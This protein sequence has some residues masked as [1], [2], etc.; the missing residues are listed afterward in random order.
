MSFFYKTGDL[1]RWLPDGNIEFIGRIDNQIKI[2]GYRIE[3]GEIESHLAKHKD[4]HAVVVS[5]RETDLCVYFAAGVKLSAAHL[6]EYLTKYLPA[7]MIPAYFMQL[8]TIPLTPGGKIDKKAL[9]G[10]GIGTAAENYEAPRGYVEEKLLDVWQEVLGYRGIGINDNF[11]EIGGDSIKAIQVAARLRTH[12]LGLGINQLFLNSTIKTLSKTVTRIERSIP[13]EIVEGQVELTPIQHWFFRSDC[14]CK[15][16]FNQAV[17]LYRA[18]GFAEDSLKRVLT[19]IAIHHDALR[20]VYEINEK[21][22]IQ[23]NRGING[24]LFDFEVMDFS[25]NKTDIEKNI[26]VEVD[27][28]QQGIDLKTGPLMKTVLFKTSQG[29]HLLMV[30]HHLVVDGVSWRILLEDLA[31]G[32]TRAIR[33]EEI[34]FPEKTDSFRH[35]ARELTGYAR[36]DSENKGRGVLNELEYWQAVHDEMAQAEPLP[37]NRETG[38][39]LQKNKFLETLEVILE[40]EDTECLLRKANWTYNTEINDILLTGLGLALREWVGVEKVCINLEGHGREPVIEGVDISRTV[41]W[42]TAQYPV[43]LDMQRFQDLSY[44]VKNVKETLRRV[45]NKGINYGILKYLVSILPPAAR[46]SFEKPPLDPAKLFTKSDPDVSFN[47]LGQVDLVPEDRDLFGFSWINSGQNVSPEWENRYALDINGILKNGRLYLSIGFNK[48]RFRKE[49]VREL[50]E[51][52]KF[53][54]VQVIRHCAAREKKE[55][56]PSDL[57]YNKISLED[58]SMILNHAEI[59]SLYPLSPM[60]SGMFYHTLKDKN[61]HAYFEQFKLSLKGEIREDLLEKSFNKLVERYDVLRTN[62]VYEK[63]DKPLQIVLKSRQVRIHYEDI[64]R[65]SASQRD[66]FLEKYRKDEWEQGF[67]LTRDMLMK[68]SLF[69]TGEDS[70]TI[71]LSSHHI[72]MDGWCSAVVYEDLVRFYGCLKEGEPI[73]PEEVTPYREYIR[74]LEKQDTEAGLRYWQ[75]YLEGYEGSTGVHRTCGLSGSDDH[76]PGYEVEEYSR[77]MDE[78]RTSQ[79]TGLAAALRV[80]LST[81]F[82]VLWAL[83]L[84]R[85]NNTPDVVF[86]AVVSDRPAEIKGIENLVGLFVNTVPVRIRIN[87]T[88]QQDFFQ[89]LRTVQDDAI[90]SRKYEYLPLADIQANAL[91]RGDL[92]DHIMV[93]ENYPVRERILHSGPG[94]RVENVEIYE[95]TNYSFNIIIIPGK[96]LE[97]R[98]N[99]N[100]RVYDRE[101]IKRVGD[102]LHYVIDQVIAAARQGDGDSCLTL[103]EIEMITENEK[104]RIMEDFN[105][106]AA[107]YSTGGTIQQ[108]FEE[109]VEKTPDSVAVVGHGCMDVWMHGNISITFRELNEKSGQLAGFLREKGVLADDIIGIMIERSIEMVIGILGILKAGAAYL[110]IDPAYPEERKQYML[111]DSGAKIL[112]TNL[113]EG[114]LIHHSSNQF[115]THHPGNLVY[116]IYTSGSTGKP[117]AV[118]LEHGT[119]VNLVKFQH[120]YTCIDFSSVLQFATISFDVSFQE[121]A[122]TLTRGGKLLVVSREIRDNLHQLFK[123]V[124]ECRIKTLFLPASFLKFIAGEEEFL[125]LIPSCVKHIVTAGEQVIVN[126]R[127]RNYL[128][129]NE[130]YLHN[131]YGPSETHAATTLTLEPGAEIPMLPPIGRPIMNSRLY[132][133]DAAGYLQPV[134][135]SGELFIS[136]VLVGRGYLNRPELTAEKFLLVSNR[137]YRSYRSYISS[138]KTYKTGDLCRWLPDGNIEF[139]GRKDHQVKIR[140]FRVE[141]G[142]IES[143]LLKLERIKDAVVLA[144]QDGAGQDYLCA[145]IVSEGRVEYPG[146]REKLSRRL[147][148][149]MIPAYMIPLERIPLTPNGKPD[150]KALPEPDLEAVEGAARYTAPVNDIEEMLVVLWSEILSM[151]KDKISTG[152]D[153]FELGGHSLKAFAVVSRIHKAFNIDVPLETIFSKPTI[154]ELGEY[155]AGAAQERFIS[156]LPAEQK[157]YYPLSPPQKRLYIIQEMD[158]TNVGYN[159]P[160]TALMEG[161]LSRERLEETFRRLIRR[162]ES[163]RTSFEMLAGEPVQRIHEDVEFEIEYYELATF[164]RPFDL[165]RAPLLRVGLIRLDDREHLFMMDMHHII[166]DGISEG[167]LIKEFMAL[168]RGLELPVLRLRYKDYVEWLCSKKEKE[169]VKQQKQYWLNRFADE[170]P[171]LDFPLD[172]GRPAVQDFAGAVVSFE[173]EKEQVRALRELALREDVTLYMVLLAIFYVFLSKL[174]GDRDIVIGTPLAGRRHADLRDIIGMFVNTLALRNSPIDEKTFTT[175]L[176]ELKQNVLEAFENQEYPFEELVEKTVKNRDTGR[177]PLFDVMF[178]FHDIEMTGNTS[179]MEIPGLKLKPHPLENKT[180]HFDWTLTGIDAGDILQFTVEYRITL[181]KPETVQRFTGYLQ[182]LVLS[183]LENPGRSI[184]SLDILSEKEKQQV[185]V[186][187]NDTRAGYPQNKTVHELFEEQAGKTPDGVALV[188][189]GQLAV[190]KKEK[191]HI[192]YRVLNEKANQIAEILRER[193]VLADDIIAMMS[194]R[195]I[196]MIIGILGILKAGG[197][198]LPIDPDY[199]EERKQYMLADSGAKILLSEL[200]EVSGLSKE[201]THL[202]HPTHLCYLIYTSGS[203]GKPK[204]VM[205]RHDSLV[206][207]VFALRK[208][209]DFDASLHDM[210]IAPFIFDVS[211]MHIFL[212]LFTGAKLFLV[213]DEVNVDP[214]KFRQ[215]IIDNRIDVFD[216]VPCHLSVLLNGLKDKQIHVKY[217]FVGGEVLT[218]DLYRRIKEVIIAGKVINSYGPTEGTINTTLYECADREVGDS[219]PIG[220]PLMNYRVYILDRG[221]NPVPVGV[222]GELWISGEGIARGYLNRPE[223]TA[224]RFCSL[225]YE[226]YRSYRTYSSYRT[227]DLA[228]WLPDGNIEFLGRVDFQVKIRG[229]RIELGEIES[230]LSGY[231]GIKETVV[232]HGRKKSGENY[233]CAYFTAGEGPVVSELRA[234]L[235]RRLPG[236]MIPAYFVPLDRM[237]LGPNG[238]LDRKRLPPPGIREGGTYVTP[239]SDREK[240]MAAVWKEVLELDRVGVEDNFFEMGGNSLDII[241]LGY[242]LNETFK[243]DI[244]VLLL[245]RYP[246]IRSLAVYLDGEAEKLSDKKKQIFSAIDRG[247]QK[248]QKR[249]KIGRGVKNGRDK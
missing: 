74:W 29:D 34:K 207:Q 103:A 201:P 156:I 188:G 120:R 22:I 202:T 68:L 104:R 64:S 246:T 57:G 236:Y 213:P 189:S 174:S 245:F 178:A 53:H 181:F 122:T 78:T 182:R 135:V 140:G 144:R 128:V 215:F 27:R 60:Q 184:R 4:M 214:M 96:C 86:G 131:H 71:L 155:I 63:L 204:G 61:S 167:I 127:F 98:F 7:Y 166:S 249:R 197:A 237:P 50:A 123:V 15:E 51:R 90:S 116:V 226:S 183:I 235:A 169:A 79:L 93:F 234:Y 81:V 69:R 241:H 224:E 229:F 43:V 210:L 65:L 225:S 228:R 186:D 175:F 145:Y 141:L 49:Q 92:I 38:R 105:R 88:E 24:K 194:D 26:A 126:E 32:Y 112:L 119:A 139:I 59:Q 110:P 40:Q 18:Q 239:G 76:K 46:G 129:K 132:I 80:T 55:L 130:I 177:N 218:G 30:I 170:I 8:E 199:P 39:N 157:E 136:G 151:E 158:K 171:V 220:M 219:I 232:V 244:P 242:R 211:I 233:L 180:A 153:F 176:G 36:N 75:E 83:L 115:V 109:Q 247:K 70:Y 77:V 148:D 217:L 62:F 152:A 41:G 172:Y 118:M 125:A 209:F 142:E 97:L 10:P 6:R 25:G 1:G 162:H 99:Y 193:G 28:V 5:A 2:R 16:H 21:G 238:K 14:N 19:K 196:E 9:P 190:G 42:F 13:Q 222:K 163:F 3:L 134:G 216:V 111:A 164:L 146:L 240:I 54:L 84:Q 185:L 138:K 94:F 91:S 208:A 124:G 168:S 102:H 23:V 192:I 73:E 117:K 114:H 113:P 121:I 149:Y 203:T 17:V 58:F 165:S 100:A 48:Y 52:Y 45:P 154:Q 107:D 82:R 31:A 191:I 133:V 198:Y 187:F 223:L 195:S 173:M 161:E 221:L 160:Q 159:L 212:V 85:Y 227:G 106:T 89:L 150:R 72:I 11:F 37:A 12:G 206:N 20:M 95:Q 101:F 66:A 56:T 248:L 143:E 200:N 47:Y 44:A 147:P 67:D 87:N 137:S 179:E 205:I 243:A 230:Q 108:L 33:G 35:W 231:E